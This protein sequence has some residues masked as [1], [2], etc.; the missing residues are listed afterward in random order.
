MEPNSVSSYV[1]LAENYLQLNRPDD[2]KKAIEQAQQRKLDDEELHWTMYLLAFYQGDAAGMEQQVNWAAG[3]PGN[4]DVLLSFQ[5]DTEAYYGR[6]AKAQD[7]SRR[8]VD[9]AVTQRL[10]R[11]RGAVAGECRSAGS[12]VRQHSGRE[13]ECCEQHWR[14][15]RAGT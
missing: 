3:K 9:S 11:N 2:A 7:F 13:A 14:W 10:E 15:L 12:G 5:S 6:L 8:A 1:N 4:E